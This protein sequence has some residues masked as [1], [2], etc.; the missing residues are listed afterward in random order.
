MWTAMRS[1]VDEESSNSAKL[2]HLWEVTGRSGP[3][4]PNP[5]SKILG[6]RMGILAT[7]TCKSFYLSTPW[8]EITLAILFTALVIVFG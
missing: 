8:G 5:S 3:N 6:Y 1:I 4:G 2:R 7:A